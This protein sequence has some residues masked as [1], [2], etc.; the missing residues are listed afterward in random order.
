MTNWKHT[1]H[2]ADTFRSDLE[3]ELKTEVIVN[4]IKRAAWYEEANSNGHLEGVLEELTDAAEED[5]ENW[6]DQAWAAFY[7]VADAE[8]VWVKTF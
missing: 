1:L 8:R 4:R 6:W 5:D 3:L 7:D 2:L